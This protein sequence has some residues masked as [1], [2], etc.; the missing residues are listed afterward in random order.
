MSSASS[1]V[2]YTSVYTD[3][4]PERVF[5]GADEELSDRGSPGCDDEFSDDDNDNDDMDDEDEE[6]FKDDEE[7]EHLALADS[8]AAPIIDPVPSVE[9]YLGI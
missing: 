1:A 7:E 2:I 6:S 9:G 8:P 4:E 5:W 3:S